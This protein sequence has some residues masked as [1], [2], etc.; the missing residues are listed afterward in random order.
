MKAPVSIECISYKKGLG[1]NLILHYGST[2]PDNLKLAYFYFTIGSVLSRMA[3]MRKG[4]GSCTKTFLFDFSQVQPQ[5][6]I[7][8]QKWSS[9]DSCVLFEDHIRSWSSKYIEIK[10][11]PNSPVCYSWRWLQIYL[12]TKVK[13]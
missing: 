6:P 3:Y 10:Y 12:C 5:S 4:S 1:G 13:Y 8:W 11:A 2:I 9:Y 7:W